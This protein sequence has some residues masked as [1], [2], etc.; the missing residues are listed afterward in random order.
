MSNEAI[1]ISASP[2]KEFGKGFARRARVAGLVPAVI[3][4]KG[5]EPIHITV[6]RI[7]FTKIV[8][9]HGSNAVIS[10]DIEGDKQLA[11]IKHVDQNV[12]TWEIDHADLLAIKKGETVEVEVPV[13][14]AGEPAPGTMVMQDADTILVSA[15]VMDI[16][17]EITVNIDGKAVGDQISAADLE[18]PSGIELAAD[19]E[20]LIVNFVAPEDNEAEADEAAEEAGVVEDAPESEKAEESAE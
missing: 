10:V 8:R 15:G 11:M 16:P 4:A 2:R 14:L 18:L 5:F 9:K 20:T 17:E 1:A 7:E 19:S 12:L 6:N 13:V 3:Y